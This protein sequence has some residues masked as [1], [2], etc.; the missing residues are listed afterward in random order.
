MRPGGRTPPLGATPTAPSNRRFPVKKWA[1]VSR[2][3]P[4]MRILPVLDLLGGQVVRGVAGRRQ[5][6]RPVVSRL[7]PSSQPLDVA[8]AFRDHFRLSELYLADLDA[9][10]GREPA[11]PLYTALREEGFRL[12]LD[13]GVRDA[14]SGR[15]LAERVVGV[16][17]G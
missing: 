8:R 12:W 16:V 3:H 10:A 17:A 15:R 2:G 11:W 9:I 1:N 7:T 4:P 14:A 6:Y 5:D 13:A